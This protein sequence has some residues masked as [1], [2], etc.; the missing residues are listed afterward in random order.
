MS[1]QEQGL[2][3]D[4]LR[5]TAHYGVDSEDDP[6]SETNHLED[7]IG[8][9]FQLRLHIV[10]KPG[11]RAPSARSNLCKMLC[12][13]FPCPHLPLPVLTEKLVASLGEAKGAVHQA[14]SGVRGATRGSCRRLV[15]GSGGSDYPF[16]QGPLPSPA[17]QSQ[18]PILAKFRL[19]KSRQEHDEDLAGLL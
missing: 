9:A 3:E 17:H 11:L 10:I 7:L 16:R 4:Q 13:H 2:E 8:G 1:R 18:C 5:A 14:A 12:E 15:R 19:R 6:G